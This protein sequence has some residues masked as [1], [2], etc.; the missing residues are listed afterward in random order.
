MFTWKIILREAEVCL[1]KYSKNA[2]WGGT[3]GNKKVVTVKP[4]MSA[5]KGS[6]NQTVLHRKNGFIIM[7]LMLE[8]R[9]YY[10]FFAA[11]RIVRLLFF[12]CDDVIFIMR[13]KCWFTSVH[14]FCESWRVGFK[15]ALF[16]LYCCK[17]Y[18]SI[19]LLS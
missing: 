1:K 2:A 16:N 14:V 5:N 6:G 9:V 11:I 15:G 13:R 12:S 8:L 18:G 3:A 10:I 4:R 7:S 19:F 17:N